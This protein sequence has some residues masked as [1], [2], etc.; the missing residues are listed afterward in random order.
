[1]IGYMGALMKSINN[2]VVRRCDE[3]EY[4]Q[5][6]S[7]TKSQVIQKEEPKIIYNNYYYNNTYNINFLVEPFK[8]I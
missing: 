7:N 5:T 1:M 8:I 2:Y 6:C 3:D 4:K